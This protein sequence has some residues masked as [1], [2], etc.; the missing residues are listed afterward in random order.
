MF[1]SQIPPLMQHF[2]HIFVMQQRM[3]QQQMQ[4]QMYQQQMA[5]QSSSAAKSGEV[6]ALKQSGVFGLLASPEGR[7]K[8]QELAGR[9]QSSK[10]RMEA[11]VPSWSAEK[12]VQYFESFAEHPALVKLGESGADAGAKIQTFLEMS[13]GDLDEMMSLLLVVA[14]NGDLMATAD[15]DQSGNSSAL[16]VV[17]ATMGS[18]SKFNK[19]GPPVHVP[20]PNRGHDHNHV[21]GPACSHHQA[22]KSNAKDV[23]HGVADSMD[24]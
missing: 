2:P 6:E 9:V 7:T 5:A 12:K 1:Y 24:R 22:L 10:Q 21:H 3:Q 16:K 19:F 11:E 20:D 15:S 4:Q 14:D 13:E 8:V 18:L 17:L 23:S